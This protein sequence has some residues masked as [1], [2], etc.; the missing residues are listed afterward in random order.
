MA[1]WQAGSARS[2]AG[3]WWPTGA[4]LVLKFFLPLVVGLAG[5]QT[6]GLVQAVDG[7]STI[8]AAAVPAIAALRC[9][10]ARAAQQPAVGNR[11]C[12]GRCPLHPE[13]DAQ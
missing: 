8:A 13:A 6:D 10:C 12:S 9:R 2:V 1:G 11:C 7:I 3:P 4:F 5:R